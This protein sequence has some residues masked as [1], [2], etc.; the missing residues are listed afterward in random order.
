MQKYLTVFSESVARFCEK[1]STFIATLRHCETEQDALA[2]IEEMRTKYWDAKHNVFAY[3]VEKGTISRF[4]D[5]GEPHSTAGKPVLDVINAA[6]LTNVAIVVT[7]Y[8]GGVLLG[9][10]GLVRAYSKSARDAVEMAEIYEMVPCRCFETV[11]DYADHKRLETI[12]ISSNGVIRDT[13]FAERIT[14]KYSLK[15]EDIDEYLKKLS[16]AFSARLIAT[17]L[18]EEMSP[19]KFFCEK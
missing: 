3:S 9:T 2:F 4:S 17:D 5:D 1:R 12:I 6:S 11:C 14:L 8:F 16:E 13:C 18:G 10:G 15:N 7:R 19:F